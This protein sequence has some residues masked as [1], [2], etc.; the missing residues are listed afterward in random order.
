M[1]KIKNIDYGLTYNYYQLYDSNI[2]NVL[3]YFQNF[4]NDNNDGPRNGN[5][6]ELRQQDFD[7]GTYRITSPG[8]YKLMEDV[9]FAPNKDISSSKIAGDTPNV[10]DNFFPTAVQHADK[11]YPSPPYQLGFFAMIT[12]EAN[13]V[14]IDLNGF[15]LRQSI[16]HY[17]QQR[18]FSIIELA[19]SPFIPGQGPSNFGPGI[20]VPEYVYIKNGQFGLSS[21]HGI[22]GNSMKNIIIENLT[23]FNYE[24]GAIALNGGENVLCRNIFI[25][26]NSHHVPVLATYSHAIFI[27]K[28]L[29]KLKDIDSKAVLNVNGSLNKNITDIINNLENE[30]IN[31]VYIPSENGTEIPTNSLFANANKLADGDVYGLLFNSRGVAVN[32]FKLN[33]IG[34]VGNTN[35][36]IHDISINKVNSSAQEIVALAID[37]NGI[38]V[39]KGPV[40]E[41]IRF[42]DITDTNGQYKSN[43]LAD[44]W[45]ILA[46]YKNNSI[47]TDTGTLNIT[48]NVVSWVES[49]DNITSIAGG[50][51]KLPYVNLHDSMFHY[52]KG[53]IPLFISAVDGF[54]CKYICMDQ[55]SNIGEKGN[56]DENKLADYKLDSEDKGINTNLH[57]KNYQ[58]SCIRNICITGS[59]NVDMEF[60]ELSGSNSNTN[61]C[62]AC[63]IIGSC[64]NIKLDHIEFNNFRAGNN[65]NSVIKEK[66]ILG[67]LPAKTMCPNPDPVTIPIRVD[68]N[69]TGVVVTNIT[70]AVQR[71]ENVPI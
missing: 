67:K 57:F 46:K 20:T 44:G 61:C 37:N 45:M 29:R 19:S 7:N 36:V 14:V 62:F 66:I 32:D 69:A 55:N 59:D 28:F 5:V 12:V 11:S 15:S 3:K 16:M 18:F 24:I 31:N 50:V 39:Q 2:L 63:D 53:N 27:R 54:K 25:S 8:Y 47:F 64:S 22:H 58:G 51:G 41:V 26:N 42:L 68:N 9:I 30:M 17:I 13:G 65:F 34:A 10:L 33:R 21:H 4:Q 38:D 23:F 49:T 1:S 6:I 60:V 40:G 43:V 35:I 56:E 70:T 48:P 71:L 52:M